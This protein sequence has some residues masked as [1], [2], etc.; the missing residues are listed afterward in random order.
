MEL[1]G[2]VGFVEDFAIARLAREA[3]IT[4]IWEGPANVQALDTL[5]VMFRKGALE[6]FLGEF[7]PA[8]ERVG[9]PSSRAA[10]G[11]LEETLARLRQADPEE[12]QWL[13]KESLRTLADVA[14]T[15]LLYGLAGT[16]GERYAK[17]AELYA[18][19]FLKGEEYS[20]WALSAPEVWGETP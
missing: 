6:P 13:A 20:S 18:S 1:F 12:A 3:L 11:A 16:S 15:A 9:T 19:R 14:I 4:P 10:L 17:L 5:E 7:V 2:G 8:L